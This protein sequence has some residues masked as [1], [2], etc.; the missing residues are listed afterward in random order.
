MLITV[1]SAP[2]NGS[3]A[4]HAEKILERQ[5]SGEI[6]GVGAVLRWRGGRQEV[7]EVEIRVAFWKSARNQGS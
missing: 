4:G 7:L 2:V 5:S 3:K 1:C 6:L